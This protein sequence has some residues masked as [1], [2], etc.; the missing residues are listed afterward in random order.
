MDWLLVDPGIVSPDLGRGEGDPGSQRAAGVRR[1][2]DPRF[3]FVDL[4]VVFFDLWVRVVDLWVA[5][6]DLWVQVVDL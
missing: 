2:L 5:F 6:S 3:A 1:S 4:W